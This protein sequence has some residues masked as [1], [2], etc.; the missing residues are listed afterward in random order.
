MEILT[1]ARTRNVPAC[2]YEMLEYIDDKDGFIAIMYGVPISVMEEQMES[3]EEAVSFLRM[4][5]NPWT[6]FSK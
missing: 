5:S 1:E 4:K 6:C 2:I 3:K